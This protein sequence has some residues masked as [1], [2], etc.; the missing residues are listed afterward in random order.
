MREVGVDETG[1]GQRSD[2]VEGEGCTFY[3]CSSARSIRSGVGEEDACWVGGRRDSSIVGRPGGLTAL[4]A[5]NPE[6]VDVVTKR[7]KSNDRRTERCDWGEEPELEIG[8][9]AGSGRPPP[10]AA[11][12]SCSAIGATQGAGVLVSREHF[13]IAN[14]ANSVVTVERVDFGTRIERMK[15]H[16]TFVGR[17]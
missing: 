2:V 9:C 8:V 4:D 7:G 17:R 11:R 13:P 14:G 5:T 15:A 6:P 3:H 12:G 10:V 16:W 1:A